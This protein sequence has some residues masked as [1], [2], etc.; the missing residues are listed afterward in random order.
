MRSYDNFHL[1]QYK[2][3]Q[4]EI[5]VEEESLP[6]EIFKKAKVVEL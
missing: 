4:I 1:R 5:A 3:L 2:T 6:K